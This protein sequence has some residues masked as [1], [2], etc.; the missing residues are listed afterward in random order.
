MDMLPPREART[1][2]RSTPSRLTILGAVTTGLLAYGVFAFAIMAI[3]DDLATIIAALLTVGVCVSVILSA[4]VED[5][6][7]RAS[8][9]G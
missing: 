1:L 9:H 6:L 3:L 7:D 5:M 4:L 8:N 2:M